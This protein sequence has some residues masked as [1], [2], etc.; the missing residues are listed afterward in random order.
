MRKQVPISSL[1]LTTLA[2]LIGALPASAETLEPWF[3]LSSSARPTYISPEAKT[4]AVNEVQELSLTLGTYEE[5]EGAVKIPDQV[6]FRLI[7]HVGGEER[8]LG[9]FATEQLDEKFQEKYGQSFPL[10]N[11]ADIKKAL[12]EKAYGAGNVEVEE[13]TGG[14]A[15]TLAFEIT[16]L[17]AIKVPSLEVE[18]S[19]V[20]GAEGHVSATTKGAIPRP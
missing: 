1:L 5:E 17:N 6:F 8:S 4:V 16:T 14:P 20:S 19:Q 12:E 7:L 9:D 15:G 13:V 11:A 18:T 10:V 2:M 3:H